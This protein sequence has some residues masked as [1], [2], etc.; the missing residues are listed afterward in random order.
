MGFIPGL[1][2]WFNIFK[3]INVIHHI[4]RRKD[5]NHMILPT[6]AEKAF[7]KIQRPVLIKTLKKVGIQTTYF[8]IIKPPYEKPTANI[9]CN[10]EKLRAFL[11]RSGT[12][13]GC[14]LSPLLFNIV[15]EILASA[16]RQQN[17]IKGIKIG[18]EEFKLS[19]F[20]DDMI[21]YIENPKDSTK[22]LLEL[23]H[24]FSKVAEY[25]INIQKSVAFL[26]TIN[27]TTEREIKEL[28][29]FTIAPKIIRYL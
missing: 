12:Q 8:N 17:K 26:Y 21:L 23:I 11:L 3:S 28:I 9:I 4:N 18:K 15:L 14:P 19:S 5:K 24:K 29:S 20:T 2:G 7:D 16:I 13:Q 27:E 25:K 22:K 10:G 6:D 1:Q